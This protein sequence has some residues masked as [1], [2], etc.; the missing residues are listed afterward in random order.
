MKRLTALIIFLIGLAFLA[1]LL[2]KVRFGVEPFNYFMKPVNIT[3]ISCPVDKDGDGLDDLK[4]IVAGARAEVSRKVQYRSAYYQGGNPPETE[5]VCTDLVWR[6][7][8]DA[9]YNLKE[10][11][12]KDIRENVLQYPRVEG[13]PDPNIDYRR[14]ANL[15][16][17]FR[18]NG[19]ELTKEIS[20][21]D[22]E[23]LYLWQPGDI[24]T[25]DYPHEHIAII[26][27]KRRPDGVPYLLHN[28]GPTANETDQLISW[29]SPIS[30]HFRFP[31]F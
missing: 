10:M 2:T 20:P 24:V 1:V 17:F 4:D 31:Q 9:G 28:A 29:P 16:V 22:E 12:D 6:S 3:Q 11:V 5:G 19:L 13:K 26:S 25:L 23:N 27:D 18:R 7:F 14:V 30:G 21:G 8:R 15:I